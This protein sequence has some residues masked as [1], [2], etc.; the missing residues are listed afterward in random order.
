[1]AKPP[2]SPFA[3]ALQRRMMRRRATIEHGDPGHR[4][5]PVWDR[6]TDNLHP[7]IR[8]N[9]AAMAAD[10]TLPLHH[11]AHALRSS[12]SFAVNLFLPFVDG[13]RDALNAYLSTE[14]NRQVVVDDIALEYFGSGDILAEI[15]GPV[16]S[17]E[18][19]L[20]QADVALFLRD[21][22]GEVG[23]LLVEVKL[24]EG[25]YT[26]CGGYPSR[27]NRR[28][29]VCESAS[30]FFQHP[31]HCYLQRPYRALRDRRYW[32][33]FAAEHGSV[34][35]A[36]PGAIT[37]DCPFKGD[38]Q[39]PMRNHA[40]ALGVVHSGRATYWAMALVHHDDNPDVV[41]PWKAYARATADREK[42]LCW[43]ASTLLPLLDQA[44]PKLEIGHWLADRYFLAL[45]RPT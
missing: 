11:M 25:E 31:E 36:F 41:G 27:G 12:Q 33:L 45:D 42:I 5:S 38:W 28:R 26:Q 16:P 3:I 23:I 37:T 15:P 32:A 1:M 9:A 22:N 44:I 14:L 30:R 35:A 43:P 24:T 40:L 4:T 18:D 6:W 17:D 8:A 19:H 2:P 10:G 29:D 39:Q 13:R 7:S 34:A 21:D 20:T